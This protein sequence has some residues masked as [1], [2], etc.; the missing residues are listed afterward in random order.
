MTTKFEHELAAAWQRVDDRLAMLQLRHHQNGDIP[1]YKAGLNPPAS[2][3]ELRQLE[4]A[5]GAPIP[6]ELVYSLRRWNGRWI[7]HDHVID[8]S[9]ISDHLS[10]AQACV[11]APDASEEETFDSVIGPVNPVFESRKRYPFG[12]HEYSGSF[13]YLDFEDPPE[14]GTRGQVIRIGE[15]PTVEYVAASFVD[16]LNL[17]AEAPV[18]DDVQDDPNFD[19]LRWRGL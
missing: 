7:A 15:E 3:E 1:F 12:G 14:G 6:F 11:L 10:V 17:I 5:W 8:L 19:P 18:L 2:E 9:P 4:L 16:F 13:L